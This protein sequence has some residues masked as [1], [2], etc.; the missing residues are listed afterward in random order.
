MMQKGVLLL[1]DGKQIILKRIYQDRSIE[2]GL[3]AYRPDARNT[4]HLMTARVSTCKKLFTPFE[5]GPLQLGCLD[6]VVAATTTFR[7]CFGDE[8]T[9]DPREQTWYQ[10]FRGGPLLCPVGLRKIPPPSFDPS[11][12]FFG[13]PKLACLAEFTSNWTPV[14]GADGT[15]L[16]LVWFQNEL[17]LPIDPKVEEWI[18]AL[19]WEGWARD[20][21]Q[22][23]ES[24]YA[25]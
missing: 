7:E 4:W 8:E 5:E 21:R 20:C 2:R 3:L 18:Q 19:D 13:L 9:M 25:L 10:P 23:D 17:A 11:K 6:P 24:R 22:N 14:S 12:A 15:S 16:T 1:N